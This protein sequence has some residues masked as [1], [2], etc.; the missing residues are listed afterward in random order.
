MLSFKNITF[1]NLN[2][3]WPKTKNI[4]KD[5][6]EQ[7]QIESQYSGYLDRQREDIND[8]KK[9]EMLLLPKNLD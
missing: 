9:E 2:K 5:V 6:V 1:A 7:I 8:F 3:I 4:E